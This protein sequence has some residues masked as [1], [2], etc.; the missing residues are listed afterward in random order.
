M[1]LIRNC[2]LIR[3]LTE[4]YDDPCADVIIE[5]RYITDI[6]GKVENPSSDLTI[7]DAAGRTLLPGLLDI[8]VHLD[9]Q[10]GEVDSLE[11]NM[12][13]DA[14]RV[15]KAAKFAGDYLAAGFTTI[16]ELGA[17]NHID[18]SLRAAINAGYITG[19]RYH[20][21]GRI[22][23]PTEA[24][25]DFYASMYKE[26][27][28]VAEVI[29]AARGELKAGADFL[30]FMA[31]GAI[32]A[33]AGDPEASIYNLD[34]IKALVH[35]AGKRGTYAAAHCD[36]RQGIRDAIAGGVRTIEH[37]S[38]IAD[39]SIEKLL[40]L[41]SYIV[42]TLLA[43]KTTI[44]NSQNV[45]R[46]MM[47]RQLRLKEEIITCISR[48]YRA[49][50][51]MGFG[52]DAGTYYNYHGKNAQEFLVRRDWIGMANIDMLLQATKYSAEIIGKDQEIGTVKKGKYADLILV[53]G[54][55]VEDIT[56]ML[57]GIS[58]VMKDGKVIRG[59]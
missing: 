22:I 9:M 8:H 30:K 58:M 20:A 26:A 51:K 52:T 50:L 36:G 29:K 47:E 16:R 56:L 37:A 23:T 18:L 41:D 43:N 46:E 14:L 57:S 2:R 24:G 21:C 11:E 55:P 3:E 32:M 5:G 28:G 10:A 33:P 44:D 42:P 48:A 1:L 19:P 39:D 54:D 59:C 25:N 38:L 6:S 49:G 15:L 7:I 17:R 34:E 31:T 53:D 13:P 12:E 27:D 40:N 45:N 4:D 35:E